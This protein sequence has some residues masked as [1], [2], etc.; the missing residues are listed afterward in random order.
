MRH[1]KSIIFN[2]FSHLVRLFIVYIK[3]SL[4]N[5][6][7]SAK[8][9]L[10]LILFDMIVWL[11]ILQAGDVEINPRPM[12]GSRGGGGGPGVRGSGPTPPGILAKMCLS[13]S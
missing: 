13:D 6:L 9:K 2:L 1:I 5:G 10:Q 12:G 4:L 11:L 8:V 7:Q 3:C